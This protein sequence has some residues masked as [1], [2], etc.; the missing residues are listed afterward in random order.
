ME[1]DS[2]NE[3]HERTEHS[4]LGADDDE[5]EPP[6]D[7]LRRIGRYLVLRKVGQGGM[8][9]V[10]AGYDEQLDRKVA[11]KLLRHRTGD[12]ARRRLAREAQALARLSHPNVVQIYEI[13][14]YEHAAYIAMEFVEGHTL[15]AWRTLQ[16]RAWPELLAVMIDAGRGLA[17]AHHKG[18]IHRDFKPENVMIDGEG[19]VRVMDFGLVHGALSDELEITPNP[20][21]LA[22]PSAP[23]LELLDSKISGSHSGLGDRL[24]MTGS[25][26]G[27]PAYMAPEQHAGR[28]TDAR[29]DQFSFCVALWELLYGERPFAGR[30]L[31]ALCV[32][33]SKHELREPERDELPGWLRK[34]VERGLAAD[35]RER[36]P[37]MDELLAALADDP[38]RR[39]GFLLGISLVLGL[40][41]AGV[42]ARDLMQQR[43]H[44]RL[45]AQCSSEGA[46]IDQL[47]NEARAQTLADA[48]AASNVSFASD[49]W[50][51]TRSQLDDYAVQWTE[52][53]GATCRETALEH[54]RSPDSRAKI[55]ACL[56]DARLALSATL[57]LLGEAKPELVAYAARL[58]HDL[59]RLAACSDEVALGR[60]AAVTDADAHAQLRAGLQRAGALELVGDYRAALALAEQLLAR[61]TTLDSPAHEAEARLLTGDIRQALGDYAIARDEYEQAFRQSGKAGNDELPLRA[62]TKL[63]ALVGGRLGRIELGRLWAKVGEMQLLRLGDARGIDA[64]NLHIS[65]ADIESSASNYDVAIASATR[66]LTLY[67]DAL[68]PSH[69]DIA[70]ALLAL[71]EVHRARDESD[72]ALALLERAL[73][74]REDAF[75]PQHPDVAAVIAHIGSVLADRGEFEAARTKHQYALQ[76]REAAFGPKHPALAS[77]LVALG[78]VE[79]MQGRNAESLPYF[80]RALAIREATLGPEHELVGAVLDNLSLVYM[81]QGE[82]ERAIR[83]SQRAQVIVERVFGP[84]HPRVAGMLTNVAQFLLMQGRLD[85]AQTAAERALEIYEATFGPEHSA[86][87]NAMLGLGSVLE[88]RGDLRGAL[89]QYQ[90]GLARFEQ[91]LGPNHYD[92]SDSLFLVADAH[93]LLGEYEPARLGFERSLALE[94]AAGAGGLRTAETRLYLARVCWEQGERETALAYA[95]GSLDDLHEVEA[96]A[97]SLAEAEAWLHEHEG[98]L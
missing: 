66:A 42:L 16:R 64:A 26:L 49:S 9:I 27:T 8:G 58:P 19:R 24:T 67:T 54:T 46:Q 65:I 81:R 86:V 28:P 88:A 36:W 62:A 71:A 84:E 40:A 47:W 57:D 17:A 25:M 10:F 14:E 50:S 3:A 11:I 35:P 20:P 13:G 45:L 60:R 73:R 7:D 37:S 95:R 23:E 78:A 34:I 82:L 87:A 48:F 41:L 4:T 76:I 96:P 2:G 30:S 56:D 80:E 31:A 12:A 70:I 61:A 21:P 43:E 98:R 85:E 74:V 52:L 33:V 32:A 18:L 75:G 22:T 29:S 83:L 69:P 90:R 55:D 89:A 79:F 5:P 59:P 51:R 44:E 77:S 72:Q 53:R 15:T 97:D 1:D 38:R 63:T 91:V 39:R 92:L 94:L 68:G 93:R 6:L